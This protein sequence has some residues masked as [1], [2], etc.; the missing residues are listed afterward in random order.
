MTEPELNATMSAELVVS[1]ADLASALPLEPL[2][3]FPNVFA[4]ARLVALME[5]ASAR[6]L[7]PS[8]GSGELSVGVTIDISHTAPTAPGETVS[9]T[10]RYLG[11]DGKLFLFEVVARDGGGEIGRGQHKR[12]IV[13]AAR[14][15]SGAAKRTATK[16]GN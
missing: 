9:A 6:L 1:T 8:L 12:A 10:A 13:S 4:T 14:L 11:R 3:T 5:I 16:T 7:R 2:D 15:E